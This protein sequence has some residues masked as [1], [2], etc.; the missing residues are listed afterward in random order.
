MAN[1]DEWVVTFADGRRMPASDFG[2]RWTVNIEDLS[3]LA[4]DLARGADAL[5]AHLVTLH[6][7]VRGARAAAGQWEA[8]VAF[9]KCD[10]THP[11]YETLERNA[12][13]AIKDL[14]TNLRALA[15]DPNGGLRQAA[16]RIFETEQ[17]TLAA[18][19]GMPATDPR[20]P[21]QRV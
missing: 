7:A 15:R 17:A 16:Q 4:D 2:K 12:C 14:A 8:G 10:P 13:Q 6:T 5:D 19:G 9:V 18:C 21:W 3:L 11:G 1:G 20:K